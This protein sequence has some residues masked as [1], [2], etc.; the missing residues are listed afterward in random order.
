MICR[1]CGAAIPDESVF[2]LRCGAQLR[3][4]PQAQ[5]RSAGSSAGAPSAG[6]VRRPSKPVGMGKYFLWWTVAL[7][8]NV[9]IVCMVLSVVF[10]FDAADRNRAGF[11]RAVLLFKLLMLLFGV[12][13]VVVLA[14]NGFPFN[15]LLNRIGPR[16]LWEL[17]QEVF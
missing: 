9:E 1:G 11:F 13:A 10:A 7:F 6:A 5:E 8:S 16:A 14:W 17:L 2:C 12:T 3:P 15:D 4:G